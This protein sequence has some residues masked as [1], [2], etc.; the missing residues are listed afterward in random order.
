V[1]GKGDT[2]VV[3]PTAAERA[4]ARRVAES[5]A[6]VPSLE[7]GAL[8]EMSAAL[9]LAAREQASTTAVLLR[10]C[11]VALKEHPRANAAYRDGRYELFGSVNVAVVLEH[12]TPVVFDADAKS[13]RELEIELSR[14]RERASR[15]ELRPP[16]LSGATFTFAD[17]GP[18]GVD[19]PS[20]VITPPQA[21]AVAC[22]AIRTAS[23]VRDRAIV[24]GEVMELTLAADHR[25]L[26]GAHAAGFAGRIK[27]LLEVATL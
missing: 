7:L 24:P 14:L 13:V 3:E 20:I 19:R 22:G 23:T 15:G 10:A 12:A 17:L 6:T 8:V 11:S 5:R 9:A 27:Q 18:Y 4:M 25:I 26:Y 21:G 2:Q 1:T 16:E